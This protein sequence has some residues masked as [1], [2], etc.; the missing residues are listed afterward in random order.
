MTEANPQSSAPEA[1]KHE[2]VVP[3]TARYYT[4][5]ELGTATREIW[6]VLH[7]YGQLARYFLRKFQPIATQERFIIAP[8]GLSRFYLDVPK[9]QR[10]GASWM[11]RE[12]RLTDISDQLAYLNQLYDHV[13]PA[14]LP[15]GVRLVL[16][17]FSQGTATVWRWA[18]AGQVP[19]HHMVLW[20]GSIPLE[21]P[22][23]TLFEARTLDLYLGDADEVIPRARAEAYLHE[24]ADK[25]IH[26]RVHWYAG[27]HTIPE[28]AIRQA[29]AAF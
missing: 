12:D 26:P 4:L 14:G 9:Y 24:L 1:Q 25:N 29:T 16:L 6:F 3:K 8:E 15:S 21:T 20:A 2:L 11:T 27:G 28:A 19:F 17:G 10:V 7:G 18:C 23:E 22:P 5:G 13:V